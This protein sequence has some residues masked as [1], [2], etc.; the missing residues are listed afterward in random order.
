MSAWLTFLL[1]AAAQPAA[2][3][4]AP[5]AVKPERICRESE[6]RTGSHIRSGRRC[7][8]AEQW[9][10]EDERRDNV[11]ADLRV[12]DGQNDLGATRPQ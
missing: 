11:P 3:P 12:T 10:A 2:P 1:A 5:P 7:R 6:R 9:R 8:T 4:A